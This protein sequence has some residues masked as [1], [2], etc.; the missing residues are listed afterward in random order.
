MRDAVLSRTP[1]SF[2]YRGGSGDLAE[3]RVR[4]WGLTSW[5]GRWYLTAHDLDRDAP[6]VFRLDRI[7][8][9]RRSGRP[10]GYDVPDSHDPVAMI[11]SSVGDD[12]GLPSTTARLLVR[13]GVAASLRK[14]GSTV[15]G[16]G[17][18]GGDVPEGWDVVELPVG[19]LPALAQEVAAYGPD[20]QVAAPAELGEMVADR[21]RAVLLAHGGSTGEEG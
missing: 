12:T 21:L 6:R 20:V 4:P 8:D 17:A 2:D 11:R 15:E 16:E 1:L 9:P 14:R 5:H 10:G 3:R 13:E 19:S 7:G 18:G